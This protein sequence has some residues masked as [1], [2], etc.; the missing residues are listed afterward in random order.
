MFVCPNKQAAGKARNIKMYMAGFFND[1]ESH[2][3]LITTKIM[4]IYSVP[5]NEGKYQ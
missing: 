5:K 1:M 3:R 4:I 2:T